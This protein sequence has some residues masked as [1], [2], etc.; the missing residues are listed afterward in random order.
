MKYA[1]EMGSNAVIY[2]RNFV[3]IGSVIQKLTGEDTQ[4]HRHTHTG[5]K[6]I[7]RDFFF[8]FFQNYGSRLKKRIHGD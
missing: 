4:L 5:S 2:M 1:G 3:K 6:V 7:P 8:F